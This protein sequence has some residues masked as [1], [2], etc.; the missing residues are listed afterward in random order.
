M[1][2]G[3]A[4]SAT[5]P[6]S[7]I[8]LDTPFTRWLVKYRYAFFALV[9]V[10]VVLPF[11]G[12]WRIGL[13]TSLYRGVADNLIDGKGYTFAGLP[14]KQ[15]YPGLPFLLA[16]MQKLTGIRDVWPVL[17]VMNACALLAL[18]AT[19]HL[20]R[21]RFPTWIAVVV[22]CGVGLNVKFVQQSHEVM[23]DM[24]FVL[25]VI[26]AMLGWERL[27]RRRST[28][29]IPSDSASLDAPANQGRWPLGWAIALLAFGLLLAVVMRPT[30]W[31]L[32]LAFVVTCAWNIVRHRDRRSMIGL[33]VL[34]GVGLIFAISDPRVR[35]LNILQGAYEKEFLSLTR[36][37][38]TR[39]I[40]NL[41]NLFTTELTETFYG[42]TLSSASIPFSVFL[43]F[44]ALLVTI[45]RPLWGLQVFILCVI[46]LLLSDV[47]RYLLMVLPAMWVGYV[48]AILWLTQK[49]RPMFRD[50]A[51]FALISMANF[52][53]LS[54]YVAFVYEQHARDFLATYRKGA[55]LRS[56]EMA[57]LIR[58]HVPENEVVIGPN[59]NVLA[60]FSGRQVRS[61]RIL[62]LDGGAI[63]KYPSLVAR[64]NPTF[65]VGP[66]TEFRQKDA[67]LY[68][69]IERGV[70]KPATLVAKVDDPNGLL[71]LS[72]MEVVVPAADWRKLPATRPVVIADRPP[73]RP[74]LTPEEIAHR[75]LKARR[76]R[77]ELRAR[78]ERKAIR[79]AREA[80]REAARNAATQPAATQPATAPVPGPQSMLTVPLDA[81]G[82]LW[83]PPGKGQGEGQHVS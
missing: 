29:G 66:H 41:P 71:W 19:Y 60:Y 32:A 46:M 78:R 1:S 58:E 4:P 15:I 18:I 45:K 76:A 63:T 83:W 11:N 38:G 48:L 80:A 70:I 7:F 40:G 82:L 39:V 59:A 62:G 21:S 74:K 14:Q 28:D 64:H 47:P 51:L 69:M 43:L 25:G 5:S 30:F 65:L 81:L 54:G 57:K 55:Y 61:G 6:R 8:Y 3:E 23:T 44:G 33:G 77:K 10:I 22:T 27:C 34:M 49:L 68:R 72:R 20:V 17:V 52:C 13:D 35:G 53:N 31:V 12:Q 67:A 36:D 24:P 73:R 26:A 9:A 16:G 37:F 42:E 56:I 2:E 79:A 75:E 50:W